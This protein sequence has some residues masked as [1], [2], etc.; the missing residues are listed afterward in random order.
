MNNNNM[1][2]R[3]I[4]G[5]TIYIGETFSEMSHGTFRSIVFQDL[6]H[7]G[8][9]IALVHGDINH[10]ILYTRFHSSC[11]T[12]ETMR[13]LDCDCVKQLEGAIQKIAEYGH[14]ILFYL[15]QEGRGCG[16]VGKSRACMNVQY[17]HDTINTFD[18][19]NQLGMIPDYR[20][21]RN[22]GDICHILHITSKFVL[23]TN[24]PDKMNA[25][26]KLGLKLERTESIEIKPNPFN[27]EYL[28]SKEQYGHHLLQT[29]NKI[30][31][32]QLPYEPTKP[33][34]PTSVPGCERFVHVASYY[35]P[36]KPVYG[37][38]L[39]EHD[40]WDQVKN[41]S[42]LVA[43]PMRDKMLITIG[44]DTLFDKR[45]ELLCQPY[46]IKVNVYYDIAT[47]DDY[48]V[49]QYEDCQ[50][51][52]PIVRIHSESL[53][54]RFPLNKRPYKERYKESL[55]KIIR[56]GRGYIV[57][58]Y[59]DGRGAGLGSFVLNQISENSTGIKYDTRDYDGA[60]KLLSSYLK[61][62]TPIILTGDSSRYIIEDACRELKIE[63]KEWIKFDKSLTGLQSLQLRFDQ[64]PG[65]LELVK[66]VDVQKL[67]DNYIVTGIGSS[68]AHAVYL[69]YLNPNIQLIHYDKF[70]DTDKPVIIFSQLLSPHINRILNKTTGPIIVITTYYSGH[71][72]RDRQS[73]YNK[74]VKRNAIIIRYPEEKPDD[75]L[76]RI[77]GP[78]AGYIICHRLLNLELPSLD[79][80][81]V[82]NNLLNQL[83]SKKAVIIIVPSNLI[84]LMSNISM[85]FVEGLFWNTPNIVDSITFAHG[86]YQ[87]GESNQLP[88]ISLVENSNFDELLE[89]RLHFAPIN[90]IIQIEL[91]FTKLI[92]LLIARSGINQLEW[93][94]KYKQHL[95]YEK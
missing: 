56:H 67:E 15:I 34:I 55:R 79:I 53:F 71:S 30:N 49:L 59:K 25:F 4:Y 12:S 24:N 68:Y 83:V 16:Y 26:N 50:D 54:N 84:P 75:T 10:P 44:D 35:L 64:L 38:L 86:V 6:I 18:A 3:P 51:V 95:I 45:K 87:M 72:R 88:V 82:N 36:I 33:F 77:Q 19:Y 93:P 13:S 90:N 89:D 20:D 29:K 73:I 57:L 1:S 14:G 43:T 48:I 66:K 70:V 11:V 8:Y 21:Y 7:K 37:E 2:K 39:V 9:I 42:G 80:P 52:D 76:I 23:L 58:L 27:Q 65:Y 78:I 74:L 60:L 31:R 81:F 41:E 85:K 63:V 17:S 61:G 28:I 92:L 32:Y 69:T 22:I 40:I 5:T 47:F 91:W 62:Y 94:G 46:W